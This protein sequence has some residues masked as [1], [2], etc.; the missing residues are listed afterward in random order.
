LPWVDDGDVVLGALCGS[1]LALAVFE[2]AGLGGGPLTEEGCCV[3][4]T[5]EAP[6]VDGWGPAP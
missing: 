2:V 4:T 3:A 6:G 1:S 5:P